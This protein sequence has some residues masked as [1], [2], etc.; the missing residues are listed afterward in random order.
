MPF[1]NKMQL[2]IYSIVAFLCRT[3]LKFGMILDIKNLTKKIR[4]TL[5]LKDISFNIGDNDIVGF[6]GPNGAGKSATLKSK[7]YL[8]VLF[9]LLY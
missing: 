4:N 2:G 1:L 6:I 9:F 7:Q 8:Q 3:F 5:I